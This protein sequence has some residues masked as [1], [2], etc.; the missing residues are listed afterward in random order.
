[1]T[2]NQCGTGDRRG[3]GWSPVAEVAANTSLSA[4][5]P[6]Y[7]I[8]RQLSQHTLTHSHA[9]AHMHTHAM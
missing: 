8:H 6:Q 9:L 2:H 7:A 1:M 4:V 5:P 3:V